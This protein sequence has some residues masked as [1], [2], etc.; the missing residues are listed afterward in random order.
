MTTPQYVVR[1]GLCTADRFRSGAGVTIDGL[2]NL[3]GVSVQT[4]LDTSVQELSQRRWVPQN[5]IGVT[6]LEAVHAA[7]GYVTPD[8]TE[9]N[10]YH[11][12]LG[13]ITPRAAEVLFTPTVSNPNPR[14][15]RLMTRICSKETDTVLVLT[16]DELSKIRARCEQATPGPW[17]SFVEG[18][19]AMSGSDFIMTGGEDIYLTGATVADQDFIAHARQDIP[20]L[21]EEVVRLQQILRAKSD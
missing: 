19:E 17:R 8:P 15:G 14:S 1:G 9:A 11:A 2:G 16:D 4:F 20:K 12:K 10:P 7:G 21:V 3:H 18:R 13:G 5:Q 6:T